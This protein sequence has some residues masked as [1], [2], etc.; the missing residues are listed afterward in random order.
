MSAGS[1]DDEL[2]GSTISPT[3][4]QSQDRLKLITSQL[5]QKQKRNYLLSLTEDEFRDKVIRP[6]F[7]RLG[8]LEGR[9]THGPEE[10]GKDCVFFQIDELTGVN[11]TVVQTKAGDIAKSAAKPS[12][13]LDVI[14]A[15]LQT[16]SRAD[17]AKRRRKAGRVAIWKK[18]GT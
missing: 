18:A 1:N 12:H 9:D 10:Y 5:T 16:A 8:Y 17:A 4:E 2:T 14:V 7:K 6:L 15:Q 13:N 11:V 3:F